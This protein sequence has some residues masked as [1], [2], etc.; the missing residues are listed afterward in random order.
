MTF[1]FFVFVFGSLFSPQRYI[2]SLHLILCLRE[3]HFSTTKSLAFQGY[4]LLGIL[5][6]ACFHY[7]RRL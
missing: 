1:G 4:G 6:R 2:N 5:F 3:F 7:L